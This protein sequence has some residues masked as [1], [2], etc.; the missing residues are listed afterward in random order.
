ML[1]VF[2]LVFASLFC[3]RKAEIV[4]RTIA[5]SSIVQECDHSVRAYLNTKIHRDAFT[6]L[7]RPNSNSK[8]ILFKDCSD[9]LFKTRAKLAYNKIYTK[10]IAKAESLAR[11][12]SL[13]PKD[14]KGA[15]EW[16]NKIYDIQKQALE[17]IKSNYYKGNK[18]PASALLE[19][20]FKR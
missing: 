1:K 16:N 3:N 13:N 12:L 8:P 9:Q 18:L 17:D 2:F 6:Q 20:V 14:L 11:D 19:A 5:A 15:I 10:R 4:E 7:C